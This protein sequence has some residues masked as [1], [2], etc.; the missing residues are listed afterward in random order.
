MIKQF[1]KVGQSV[2][3]QDYYDVF[4]CGLALRMTFDDKDI[5][6]QVADSINSTIDGE[7]K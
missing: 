3:N 7:T 1:A 5:A 4:V 2:I 6:I